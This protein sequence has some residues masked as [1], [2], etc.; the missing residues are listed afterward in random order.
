MPNITLEKPWSYRTPAK[1]IDYPAGTHDVFQYIA[2]Q[3]EADGAITGTDAV[4]PLDSS[5]EVLTAHLATVDDPAEIERLLR[6]EEAGK[7]RKGALD[8]L[9]DRKAELNGDAE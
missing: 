4:D 9:Q 6:N 2:D 3:A 8:A 5:I 7:T 1:T